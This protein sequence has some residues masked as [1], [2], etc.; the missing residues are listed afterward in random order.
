MGTAG[1][2]H[3]V[4]IGLGEESTYGTPVARTQFLDINSESLA[5]AHERI[6]SG[7]LNQIGVRR[8]RVNNG[9]FRVSGDATL[10][11]P[12][13]DA[14]FLLKH[15]L[16]SVATTGPVDFAYTHTFDIADALPTGLTVEIFRDSSNFLGTNDD[17]SFI[18]EGCKV[19]TLALSASVGSYLSAVAGFV[20]EDENRSAKTVAATVNADL[21]ATRD[22]MT[23]TQG[24]VTY[25][26]VTV[27]VESFDLTINN[28]LNADRFRLGSRITREPV[29]GGKIE[30]S[31]SL[32]MDFDSFARYDQFKASATR[33][34]VL[35]FTGGNVPSSGTAQSMTITLPFILPTS[36]DL[37]VDDG[38][39]LTQTVPFVALRDPGEAAPNAEIRIVL[40]NENASV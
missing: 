34:L 17:Q 27:N 13:R 4:Y 18:Y 9:L 37:N 40:V 38:G 8:E 3:T 1:F 16:G 14:E 28:N 31:G 24:A 39:I 26:A 5:L 20:G 11:L 7:S 32:V 30:I 36:V 23:F 35:T 22:L 33:Q 2:G 10:D 6:T 25:D 21:N 19:N 29:R 12:Y 15:A